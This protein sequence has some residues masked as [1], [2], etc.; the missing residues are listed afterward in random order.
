MFE[1]GLEEEVKSLMQSG[2]T[3][4]SPGLKAIGYHE[5][6][7]YKEISQIKK[8]ITHNTRKYAKKQYTYIRDIPNS[9]VI[10]FKTPAEDL[11][12]VCTI[13]KER[14]SI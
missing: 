6:F 9:I 10:P 4:D 12:K 8:S 5:W 11:E 7:E 13:I 3:K 1:Q 2:Y 14:L